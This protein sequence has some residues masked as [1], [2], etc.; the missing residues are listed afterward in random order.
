MACLLFLSI[1]RRYVLVQQLPMLF[2]QLFDT[3]SRCQRNEWPVRLE[4]IKS[5]LSLSLILYVIRINAIFFMLL[6]CCG[7]TCLV[8]PTIFLNSYLTLVFNPKT[9]F[10]LK[11]PF[12]SLIYSAAKSAPFTNPILFF[13][14]CF[15]SIS[16][17]SEL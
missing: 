17:I 2:C 13:A 15:I 12:L 10:M 1:H 7:L 16:S 9:S 5:S 6:I 8:T 4:K 14:V 11:T 3:T